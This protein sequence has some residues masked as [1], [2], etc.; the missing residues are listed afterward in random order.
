MKK[1]LQ[2][3]VDLAIVSVQFL[4]SHIYEIRLHHAQNESEKQNKIE[5]NFPKTKH[6]GDKC[7]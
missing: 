6:E 1:L 4:L 2:I 5:I 7:L 3:Y